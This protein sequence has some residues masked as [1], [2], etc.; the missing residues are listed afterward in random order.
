MNELNKI[1][2]LRKDGLKILSLCG[3]IETGILALQHLDIPIAEYHTYE[4]LPEA[5]A[6]SSYH[7]PWIIHHGD[8][9]DAD[10]NDYKGFDLV[11]GGMCC[12]GGDEI[13]FTKEGYKKISDIEVGDYVL[14]HKN[15][16]R[17]VINKFDNGIKLT[18]DLYT[19]QSSKIECTPDHKFYARKFER[20]WDSAI[21]HDRRFFSE[22]EWVEA[23]NLGREYYLGTPVNKLEEIPYYDGI[24]VKQNK[25]KVIHKNELGYKLKQE[26]FWEMVG[27]FIGDGW[28]S[29]Y[30]YK[31][32]T[33]SI[34]S[35]KR[36]IICCSHN[37]K[38]ELKEIISNA[39]Y[40]Y[41]ITKHRTTYEFQISNFEL[42][43]YLLQFGKGA[44]NKHLTRDIFNLPCNLLNAFLNGYMGADGCYLK[45]K[46]IFQFT[47]VS[48]QLAYDISSCWNK[49]HKIHTSVTLSKRQGK[50]KIEDR[51]IKQKDN[52]IV[53]CPLQHNKQDKAFY[54]DGYIWSP[55]RRIENN[56]KEQNVYDIEV[57]EDHSYIVNNVIVHNCQSLS[58]VRI[59]NKEVNNGL[60]GKSGIVY[61]LQ[62]ALDIIHPKWFMAE[63]V[64]PS[65]EDDLK[66]INR[67]MGVDGVLINSNRF[68]AQDRER[69]YWTNI[70]ITPIPESNP[71]VLKDIMESDVD[72]KYFYKKDF[73][74]LDMNKKVCAELKVNSM[75]MN[76]RI[77]NPEFKC[78]TLT[79]INGG[80]HEKKVLD[81][82]RPRKLTEIEYERLQG[83]PD[84]FTNVL[85]NG[86]KIPYTKRCSLMGNAWNEPTIEHIFRGLKN[87]LGK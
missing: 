54:E 2:T 85:V 16:Y 41:S 87:V 72:E 6:V 27:R 10:W 50:Y 56:N 58:R 82:G 9:F 8:L 3:G 47:T 49:V 60:L 64:I 71:L 32:K 30:E 57:E 5:I 52:Y 17:K 31:R 7:F 76:R 75:E 25:H 63:N 43:C 40:V 62:K 74:I 15:R 35:I 78:A 46:N 66:E 73:E 18:I 70:P 48:K 26:S 69:Y 29:E 33:G 68:S 84:N 14:T 65:D 81:N 20:K 51:I 79:C 39:G 55:F 80:Y 22:P 1:N 53:R 23:K 24:D 11:I 45:D 36:V 21:K 19:M 83:V 34:R 86:R 38:E 59:E 13:V 44:E 37:E 42:A 77:Y 12:F 4:I 28:V 61:E 67:I